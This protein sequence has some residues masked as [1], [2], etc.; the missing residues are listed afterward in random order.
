MTKTEI[1]I[2]RDKAGEPLKPYWKV[3]VGGGRVA[4]ALRADF[5]KHLELVQREIPFDY[6][7]MHG[8]FHE[9]MMVYRE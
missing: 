1:T 2:E 9:D 6:M 7:R 3:C 5:Q 8:L 4:E